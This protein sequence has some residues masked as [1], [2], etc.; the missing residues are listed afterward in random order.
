MSKTSE[1]T[2]EAAAQWVI[3]LG[4]NCSETERRAFG[5]W[6]AADPR[7]RIAYEEA[8]ELWHELDGVVAALAGGDARPLPPPVIAETAMPLPAPAAR[9]SSYGWQGV[10]TLAAAVLLALTL[11]AG[12]ELNVWLRADL[13]TPVGVSLSQRLDDGSMV[14]LNTASA[15]AL[16]Y[17]DEARV[18]DLL[19]GE[20]AFEV[21]HDPERPFI[22][23][24]RDGSAT[25]LGTVF[26]VRSDEAR[27]RVIVTVTEGSVRVQTPQTSVDLAAGEQASYQSDGH[28]G[29]IQTIDE[30][31]AS[32]W[33][34]GYISFVNQPLEEVVR[35][36]NRYARGHIALTDRSLRAQ[37]VSGT[38]ETARAH[39]A[40]DALEQNLDLHI[41]RYGSRLTLVG[42]PGAG[43]SHSVSFD[44]RNAG[45]D[46][47]AGRQDR[48][49]W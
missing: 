33:R 41:R 1:E 7:H 2:R 14:Q 13:H 25:A 23:R 4:G 46:D 26:Q 29:A 24:T 3:R 17:S 6:L 9:T 21:A 27:E 32:A 18:V 31:T 37:P 22:V 38:F 19:R 48:R 44:V 43:N 20:A 49:E 36:L 35:E 30:Y 47:Q 8:S 16:R 28:I 40:L 5:Q 39:D 45:G 11:L 12:P 42:R 34:R 15:I 10:G